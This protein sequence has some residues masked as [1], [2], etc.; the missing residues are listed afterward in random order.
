[1]KRLPYSLLGASL[2]VVALTAAQCGRPPAP[3][4]TATPPVAVEA[5]VAQA[6][7]APVADSQPAEANNTAP[8]EANTGAA[9]IAQADGGLVP[10]PNADGR[11]GY[12]D[13]SGTVIIEPQFLYAERFIEGRAVVQVDLDRW[14]VIDERGVF[15]TEPVYQAVV[16]YRDGLAAVQKH[17]RGLFWRPPIN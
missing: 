12:I 4:P 13:A 7:V 3:E 1:M 11:Y 17:I 15:I 8:A 14:G 6:V 10:V 16:A 9:T 2:L 5:P